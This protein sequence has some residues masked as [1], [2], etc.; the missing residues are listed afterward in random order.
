MSSYGSPKF[1]H[2]RDCP[3]EQCERPRERARAE[4]AAQAKGAYAAGLQRADRVADA[5]AVG[6][7]DR[8]GGP[9]LDDFL[10]GARAVSSAY[11]IVE[12]DSQ[13]A[14]RRDISLHLGWPF[15][16]AAAGELRRAAAAAG[17]VR[18]SPFAPHQ[19]EGLSVPI[20]HGG[21]AGVSWQFTIE[22]VPGGRAL[23]LATEAV[24]IANSCRPGAAAHRR[25]TPL[26]TQHVQTSGDST[27]TIS[28]SP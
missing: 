13:A 11:A 22:G 7:F 17:V 14:P 4:A 25:L 6:V 28:T 9:G 8:A 23:G 19:D 10:R 24:R 5:P 16:E 2:D 27:C 12:G 18:P 3:C 1:V 21:L 15:D 26:Q 20:R